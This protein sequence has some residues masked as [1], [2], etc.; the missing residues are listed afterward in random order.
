MTTFKQFLENRNKKQLVGTCVNSFDEDANCIIPQL[1]YGDTT[2]FAQAEENATK[3]TKE[4]F[5]Q[6]VNVPK[7]IINIDAFYLHDENND[8]Y[9][10]YDDKLDIHYF[11]V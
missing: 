5:L 2:E 4:E 1:P 10:L 3:I 7:E 6:N 11:F 9:M 8:V